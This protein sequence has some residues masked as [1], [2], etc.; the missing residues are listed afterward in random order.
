MLED[1]KFMNV[2]LQEAQMAMIADEVP[3]GAVIVHQG[4]IIAK[5]HNLKEGNQDVLA[6]A[7]L[8]AIRQAESKFKNWRLLDCTIY[9]TLEP[10]PMCASAIQQARINRIVYGTSNADTQNE[11]I[12]SQIFSLSAINPTVQI[13]KNVMEEE[14]RELLN[15]FFR[16][17]RKKIIQMFDLI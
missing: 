3:I 8:L 5:A 17:K 15:T 16:K 7:E 2:A 13:T 12:I 11:K 10:C 4:K 14:C 1:E 6:H 9:V